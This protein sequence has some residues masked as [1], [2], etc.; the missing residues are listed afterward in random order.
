MAIDVG[1][2]EKDDFEHL[3]YATSHQMILVTFDRPFAG[4]AS[5]RGDHGAI[6]CL[7]TELQVDIGGIVRTLS[8]FAELY[9]P[10]KDAGQVFWL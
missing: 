10:E 3:A 5:M 4:K 1:M 9:D 8:E 7:P 2:S 6:V